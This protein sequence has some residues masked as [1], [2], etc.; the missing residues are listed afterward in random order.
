MPVIENFVHVSFVM[1]KSTSLQKARHVKKQ[2]AEG[3]FIRTRKARQ[4]KCQIIAEKS[5]LIKAQF[6]K[7]INALQKHNENLQRQNT[8]LTNQNNILQE[9]LRR[10]NNGKFDEIINQIQNTVNTLQ[11]SIQP[12]QVNRLVCS[13]AS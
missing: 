2:S 5:S 13:Y 8:T 7:Q 3:K 12:N 1:S 4:R 11:N 6:T 10:K 9:K